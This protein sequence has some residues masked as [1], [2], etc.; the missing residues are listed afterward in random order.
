MISL[1]TAFANSAVGNLGVV[2]IVVVIVMHS[3]SAVLVC[4]FREGVLDL[5][6]SGPKCKVRDADCNLHSICW[7]PKKYLSKKYHR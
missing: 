5:V 2:A 6:L 3:V 1:K 4:C 7:V